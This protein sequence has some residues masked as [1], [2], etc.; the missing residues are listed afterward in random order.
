[1]GRT[2]TTESGGNHLDTGVVSGLGL[3]VFPTPMAIPTIRAAIVSPWA[4]MRVRIMYWD[5]L[6]LPV[7]KLYSP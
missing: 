2:L 7:R 6:V 5:I 3:L 4:T 1:M